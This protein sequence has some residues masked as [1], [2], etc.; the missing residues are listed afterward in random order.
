MQR[1][2]S[3][4]RTAA[5]VASA[6][7]A[8]F[9]MLAAPAP[10]AAQP[11]C[12][13]PA[14]FVSTI[15][16][17][18]QLVLAS[19]TTVAAT[20]DMPVCAGDVVE[21]TQNSRAIVFI[22]AS[23][24]RLVLDQNSRL[25]VP[26]ATDTRPY[27]T[28]LRGALLFITRLR[29]SF[30]VRTPFVNA[31][32]E[33][34]EFVVRVGPNE[35]TVTVLEG[36][37]R[38]V[39]GMGAVVVGAG[40]QAVAVDNQPPL[41]QVNVRPRDAVQ[42][43]VYYEPIVP[44]DSLE[45][46]D[47]VA[48]ADQDAPFFVRRAALLLGTGQI[49]AAR[50]DLDQAQKLDPRSGD[51]FA[52]R[53]ITAV[54]LN[55]K[56]Q[57]LE[58]GRRAVEL[59]PNS[60]PARLA[61]S[62][63][64]QANFQLEEARDVVAQAVITAPNDASAWARLSELRLMLDDV[65]GA[66]DAAQRAVKL[67]PELGR[68]RT[69]LGFTQLAQLKFGDA[70]QTFEQALGLQSNDPLAHFGRG[71]A[72][73]R[74]G[75]LEE[76]RSDLETAVALSPENAILRS[77]LGK[78]YFDERRDT[79]AGEQFA[80]AKAID[81]LDP[82]P[83]YYDAIREQTINR[84]VQAL[85]NVQNA[86]RLNDNRAVYRSSFLLDQDLAARSASLGR[87]YRDLG[88][89]RLALVEAWRSVETDP[90]EHAGHRFLADL[91][92][93]FPRHEVA[94]VSELLQAQLLQPINLTPVSP[95]LAETDLFI[96][97]GAGPDAL[98][99]NEFNPL[100]N[101]NRVGVQ[102]SGALG[103][104]GIT[105][106][107]VTVSGVWNRLSFSAG[108]FHYDTTG[109]RDNNSQ[110]R[111]LYNLFAQAQLSNRTSV[112]GEVR[113]EQHR[114]GD[115][116][117]GFDATDFVPDQQTRTDGTTV[118]VGVRHVFSPRAQV[119]GSL[120]ARTQDVSFAE[121]FSDFGVTEAARY[122]QT[123]DAYTGEVRYL[124]D[125]GRF[126]LTGGGGRFRNDFHRNSSSE[127]LFDDFP[128][129]PPIQTSVQRSLTPEQTNLYSY[130]TIDVAKALTVTAGL[131]GDW[132]DR[133]S[134]TRHQVNPKVGVTWRVTTSTTVRVAAF[135]ALHR[136]VVSN[137]TLEPTHVAGFSQLFADVEGTE[138]RR[139]GVAVDQEFRRNVFAG[140]EYAA[141]D[142]RVPVE[143][144]EFSSNQLTVSRHRRTEQFGRLYAYWTPSR[145]FATSAGYSFE[146]FGGDP[147][148]SAIEGV[149]FVRTHRVPLELRYFAPAG[150]AARLSA[151]YVRQRGLFFTG[152]AEDRFWV[153]NAGV[154]YR[155]PQRYGRL[156]LEV[157]NLLD[158]KFNYQDTDPTNPA[159]RRG[160][161]AVVKF[162]IGI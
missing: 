44:A 96:L 10:A 19:G 91:Y 26:A 16:N 111:N 93:T 42:W 60:T 143:T 15:D 92:S 28:L 122:T 153:L 49:A 138:S 136:A 41:L 57:A 126:R 127:F 54:A 94:R 77:Y 113:V 13:Q 124:L 55:D 17:R 79:L 38:A 87:L 32:V 24:S 116:L 78:A 135:R 103:N 107:E 66:A 128:D 89:E 12:A 133:Q 22:T 146:R 34:T 11:R 71:L 104:E 83:Y 59:S 119:I 148:A 98:A 64:L 106:E 84:P 69:V 33:G 88:F 6:A 123:S 3:V 130:S 46:L 109:L 36:T 50:A 82:T 43:A 51:A 52:V 63:A 5:G 140:V 39:N 152:R 99:F 112:Q 80:S 137:Q 160:R 76:G 110:D 81:P 27:V 132:Y 18:V 67:A 117:I 114:V 70:E 35:T 8:L 161:L 125:L 115:L 141:R 53:A 86:I 156:A 159:I 90:G 23:N 14:A 155:I 25:V 68:P 31:S 139:Y 150:I 95:R 142:L 144:R 97:E 151:D 45:R 72:Q 2:G 105:G 48:V 40:Q 134:F 129:E 62:Y 56:A 1:S 145:S 157:R 73:I 37:V 147:R 21:V 47:A 61:L 158:E 131:S 75:Q 9:T 121:R 102:F 20:R 74:R 4:L 118:R 85:A 108:Q 162:T 29:R 149:V 7:L 30:E 58:S 65:G 120:Y 100:F 101:R 154:S